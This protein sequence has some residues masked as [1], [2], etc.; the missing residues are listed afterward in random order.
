M[1]LA[2]S[3]PKLEAPPWPATLEESQSIVAEDTAVHRVESSASTCVIYDGWAV[4]LCGSYGSYWLVLCVPTE[5]FYS[6]GCS[7]A[8]A[9]CRTC[10]CNNN[11]QALCWHSEGQSGLALLFHTALAQQSIAF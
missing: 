10:W 9:P 11:F 5:H 6:A 4:V 3:D 7:N 8:V 1:V 2:A